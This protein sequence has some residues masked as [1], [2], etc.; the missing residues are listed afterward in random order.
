VL[1]AAC[2]ATNFVADVSF[3]ECVRIPCDT[4]GKF[5]MARPPSPALETSALPDLA[6]FAVPQK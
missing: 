5:A 6:F 4:F 2:R 3:A 1:V